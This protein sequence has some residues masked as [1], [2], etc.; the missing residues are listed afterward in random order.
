[1]I[2]SQHSFYPQGYTRPSLLQQYAL[3]LCGSSSDVE[4]VAMAPV[5]LQQRSHTCI[6]GTLRRVMSWS[7]IRQTRPREVA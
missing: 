2:V 4:Y 3:H 6:D 5:I 1:M 7:L